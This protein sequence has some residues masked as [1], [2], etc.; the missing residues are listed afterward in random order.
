MSRSFFNSKLK[1]SD[2]CF[3]ELQTDCVIQQIIKNDGQVKKYSNGG[4]SRSDWRNSR[5][6]NA[7]PSKKDASI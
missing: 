4:Y 2:I 7:R 3:I 6:V 1:S 5:N